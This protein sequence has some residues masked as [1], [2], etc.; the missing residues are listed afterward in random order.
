MNVYELLNSTVALKKRFDLI[1]DFPYERREELDTTDEKNIYDLIKNICSIA[2]NVKDDG[3]EFCPSFI[4][5]G[6]RTYSLEDVS[7]EDYTMLLTLDHKKLPISVRARITDVL[8]VQKRDYKMAIIAAESYYELF[9]SLFKDDD[10]FIALKL[11]RRAAQ[12]TLQVNKTDLHEQICKTIYDHL[13]R[14]D[15]ADAQFLSISLIE[16]LIKNCYGDANRILLVIDKIL[17]VSRNDPNKM[18]RAFELKFKYLNRVEGLESAKSVNIDMA[19]Y[20]VDYGEQI[21]NYDKLGAIRSEPY[22]QKAIFLFRNNGAAELAEQTHRRLVEVQKEIF[23]SMASHKQKIDVSGIVERISNYMEGLSFEECVVRLSQITHLYTKQEGE[24]NVIDDL[25]K[26]PLSHMFETNV[27]NSDGQ[28]VLSLKPLDITDPCK[29]AELLEQHINHKLFELEDLSGNFH[30]S[31]ALKYIREHFDISNQTLD[32]IFNNNAIIP[33]TRKNIIERGIRLAFEGDCFAAVHILAPQAE[34]IFRY[35]AKISGALTV[36]LEN[37]GSSKQKTLTSI[38]DLPELL[39][40][41]DNNIIFLFKGLLNEQSG[42]NIRNEIAHGIME[43]AK[44]ATGACVYFI[45]A[46]IKLLVILSPQCLDMLLAMETPTAHM[47]L[48]V[49]DVEIIDG[50]SN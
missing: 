28:T 35:I 32:F 30:L 37:D 18:E 38:F 33:I 47:D 48:S 15:G 9:N 42:A 16:L 17:S 1:S 10:W 45:C 41:Y 27:I 46:L 22:F 26:Y 21:L 5:D 25:T 29:D 50:D 14:I 24:K 19:T 3:V 23:K 34:N 7:K 8:W 31:F 39:D 6:K 20:F 2:M 12:I 44:G 4:F 11:I 49:D 13:I 36:T 43:E 40:C